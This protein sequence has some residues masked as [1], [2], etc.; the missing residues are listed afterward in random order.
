MKVNELTKIL[1][2]EGAID[3]ENEDESLGKYACF[4][5]TRKGT[6]TACLDSFFHIGLN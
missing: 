3:P 1:I 6:C 2:K 5:C 4:D